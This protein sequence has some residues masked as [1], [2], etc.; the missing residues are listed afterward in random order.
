M[1]L[2]PNETE[3]PSFYE[4]P[5]RYAKLGLRDSWLQ[6]HLKTLSERYEEESLPLTNEECG[7]S[8]QLLQDKFVNIL[9]EHW[10]VCSV[11]LMQNA[12]YVVQLRRKETPFV[13][14]LPLDRHKGIS[15]EEAL[16]E[17]RAIIQGSDETIHNSLNCT[18]KSA[19]E[20]WWKRR[21]ELDTRLKTLLEKMEQDWLSGFKGILSARAPEF[22]E[23]LT[24]FQRGLSECV[25]KLV[26]AVIPSLKQ[27]DF[28]LALCRVILRLGR[29]PT[30]HELDDV[31]R[32]LVLTY[33]EQQQQQQQQTTNE[34]ESKVDYKKLTEQMRVLLGRYHEKCSM[35]GIDSCLK[36]GAASKEHVILIL[37]KHLQMF[38]IESLPTLRAQSSSRLPCLSFLRDRIL[39]VQAQQRSLTT[40]W[41]DLKVS[42][43]SAYYV[44]NPGGDLRDTQ[45]AF[46]PLFKSVPDWDG[47]IQTTPMELECRRALESYDVYM[48]FGHS[49]GQA[50]MRGTTVRQMPKCA[51]S[52]LMGCS[53]GVL[54]SNGQFESYGYV[55]NYLLA[56]SPAVVANLWDV[57]DRS[58]DRLTK[59]M[60]NAWG[61][62]SATGGKSIVQA[63]AESRSQCSLPYLIGAAP[64]VY[65]IP[66]YTTEDIL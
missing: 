7:D 61:M 56:G 51:V 49:A 47:V 62:T 52:L 9:P 31:T 11:T 8:H 37:D 24:R 58:I 48:Y 63:V 22:K 57:T 25:H 40:D 18:E 59:H 32:F 2:I 38:P 6:T 12:L 21:K 34:L 33:G 66:V 20:A 30:P 26:K 35:A 10:T 28:S 27:V 60:L 42:K 36:K 19:I 50:F 64:V 39:Y 17:L 4:Q 44:L 15:Y 13:L 3:W 54:E 16:A 43:R 45:R 23:E 41:Q 46:E 5:Q 1:T 14:R 55:L 65:G 53:S 29:Y